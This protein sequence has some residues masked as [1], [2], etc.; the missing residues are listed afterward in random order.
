M[1]T[2]SDLSWWVPLSFQL[3]EARRELPKVLP[4]RAVLRMVLAVFLVVALGAHYLPTYI[5]CLE[6]DWMTALLKCLAALVLL[7]ASC[8]LIL[9]LP[10]RVK[11]TPNGISV[12]HGQSFVHFPY[13][14]LTEL[15][16]ED[17]DAHPIL[18][19]RRR[20]QSTVRR[21]A[22]A[23][24][25]ALDALQGNTDWGGGCLFAGTVALY[26]AFGI[27]S[28]WYLVLKMN[29]SEAPSSFGRGLLKALSM[30]RRTRVIVALSCILVAQLWSILVL[31]LATNYG[32]MGASC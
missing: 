8:W 7:L 31:G 25:I 1:K 2:I 13:A 22:I 14:E 16:I 6:F 19:L 29:E 3:A 23:A 12:S 10:S 30:H 9:I 15:R 17:R 20:D 26:V 5:P 28:A 18:V 24:K 27:T 11:V 4:R 32:F 21:Y